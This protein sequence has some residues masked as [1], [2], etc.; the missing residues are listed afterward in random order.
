MSGVF[1]DLQGAQSVAHPERGIA[2]YVA[3]LATALTRVAPDVVDAFVH[4]PARPL[5]STLDELRG[6]AKLVTATDPALDAAR[7]FHVASPFE[8]LVAGDALVPPAVRRAGARLV[9]TLYDLIPLVFPDDFLFSGYE[10]ALYRRGLELVRACDA[11]VAI[12]EATALDAER[13]L[14]VRRSRIT[15]VGAGAAAT[16]RPPTRSSAKIVGSLHAQLPRLRD[17]YVFLPTGIDPRKNWREAL[18]AYASLERSQR[19]RHQLV[20][21]CRVDDA[22]RRT[23]S[24]LGR[25]LGIDDDLLVTGVVDDATLVALYQGA[26]VVLYPSRYEGFGLPLLEARLCDAPAICGDNSSLREV[27]VDP[28][29][30]FDADDPAAIATV[31]RRVLD[32]EA[33]RA[34]LLATPPPAFTW[35]LA[36]QRT[37]ERYEALLSGRTRPRA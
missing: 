23:L 9:A 14:G 7:V 22:Q 13:L 15:V 19:A 8:H 26:R 30:R 28:E 36:A 21:T 34:R 32:D 35:D 1:Y 37:A 5:P 18:V 16:F 33:F 29:A 20:L 4:D 27:V 31:L 2:R 17:G 25:E 11:I 6:R 24:A 3:E 12:S 10:R